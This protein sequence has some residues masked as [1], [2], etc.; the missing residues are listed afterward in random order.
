MFC[1]NCGTQNDEG[2]K[3]CV[4]CGTG[5][6]EIPEQ[7]P[8]EEI[9]V[10]EVNDEVGI[11]E[12][13]DPV[14]NQKKSF[15]DMLKNPKNIII[16]VAVLVVVVL[17][18]A[19]I[20]LFGSDEVDFDKYPLV[21]TSDGKV[22]VLPYGEDES[23]KLGNNIDFADVS[24]SEG[25]DY[26]Y[27]VENGKLYCREADDLEARDDRLASD[28]ASYT[29]LG[30]TENVVYKTNDGDLYFHDLDE[31]YKIAKDVE[32][33]SFDENYKNVKYLTD[34][35]KLYIRGLGEN[36]DDLMDDEL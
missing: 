5:L 9:G 2:A 21:Y 22:K 31:K 23:Y 27:F 19:G 14:S 1:T 26:I 3:F 17:I 4:N 6:E 29:I 16:A 34:N 10:Q 20:S 15:L 33:Y 7:V 24:F 28:V 30:D 18:V 13:T 8:V 11:T 35:G 32:S 12:F 25:A 36:D